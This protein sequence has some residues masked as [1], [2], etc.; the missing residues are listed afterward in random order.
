MIMYILK[1]LYDKY[2]LKV[3]YDYVY[4]TKCLIIYLLDFQAF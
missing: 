3:L 1:V 4:K 2:I